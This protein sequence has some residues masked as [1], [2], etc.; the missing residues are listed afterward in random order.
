MGGQC[1]CRFA[2]GPGIP[3]YPIAQ[4]ADWAPGQVWTGAENFATTRIRSPD[5]LGPGILRSSTLPL[6]TVNRSSICNHRRIRPMIPTIHWAYYKPKV[7]K[8]SIRCYICRGKFEILPSTLPR[9]I[10][11][12][13]TILRLPK[14]LYHMKHYL[15]NRINS[16]I[17]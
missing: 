14:C 16:F 4:E 10:W 9:T 12:T 15:I 17:C 11:Y 6:C 8:G 7:T 3:R 13:P 2:L 5:R 1:H